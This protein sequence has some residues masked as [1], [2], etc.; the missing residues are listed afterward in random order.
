[1]KL[2]IPKEYKNR[3]SITGYGGQEIVL[4]LTMQTGTY[5]HNEVEYTC[6]PTEIL[7]VFN[8]AI[9]NIS[10][11]LVWTEET[12]DNPTYKWTS[13]GK[14]KWDSFLKGGKS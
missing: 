14:R 11:P 8:F 4:R 13:D 5:G 2:R 10:K 3:M 7:Q 6:L 12:K 1:M 9:G